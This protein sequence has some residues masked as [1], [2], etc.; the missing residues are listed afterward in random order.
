MQTIHL[1]GH[2][3]GKY[4]HVWKD[5]AGNVQIRV[6]DNEDCLVSRVRVS[7]AGVERVWYPEPETES[8]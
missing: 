1:P 7:G 2:N 3:G 4:V 6:I 8:R 5:R